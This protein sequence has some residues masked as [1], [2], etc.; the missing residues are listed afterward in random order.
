MQCVVVVL[1]ALQGVKDLGAPR[2][3]TTEFRHPGS[4]CLLGPVRQ[5]VPQVQV[6]LHVAALQQRVLRAQAQAARGE[7]E[8]R[9]RRS[10]AGRRGPLPRAAEQRHGGRPGSA[11]APAALPWGGGGGFRAGA[12]GGLGLGLGS[13]SGSRSEPREI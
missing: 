1:V 8:G 12:R 13:G 4:L 6:P 11:Q 2:D 3:V 5:G 10:P 7:G 9:P